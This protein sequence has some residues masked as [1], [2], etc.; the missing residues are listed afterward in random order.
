[1]NIVDRAREL[2][3]V[4]E[5]NAETM[6]DE[7]SLAYSELFPNWKTETKYLKD[8]RVRYENI[9]YKCVQEHISQL[10]WTPDVTPALWVVVSIDEWPEWVQPTGA[11]DAYMKGDKVSHIGKHWVCDIDNNV[12]EPSVYG[13]SEV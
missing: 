1:M 5:S 13:W 2:R 3:Q 12:Y 11:H 7:D 9:L 6:N 8:I 4:I 10:D